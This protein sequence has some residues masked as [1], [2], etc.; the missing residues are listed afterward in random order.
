MKLFFKYF[1]I[2][3]FA[4]N[5][6][7]RYDRIDD[8]IPAPDFD[9]SP[10][11][12]IGIDQDITFTASAD[13][14]IQSYL[15]EFGDGNSS[16]DQSPQTVYDKGGRYAVKLTLTAQGGQAFSIEKNYLSTLSK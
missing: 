7:C 3:I 13:F 12:Q 9:F 6:H 2:L 16:T 10:A 1:L 5:L 4:G 15:W 8:A 14:E 11:T